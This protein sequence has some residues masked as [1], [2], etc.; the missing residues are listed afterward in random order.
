[1]TELIAFFLGMSLVI[2][3]FLWISHESIR[4]YWA[5]AEQRVKWLEAALWADAAEEEH[6][7]SD[8]DLGL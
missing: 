4:R 8:E 1:M 7:A 5:S 2:N 6:F 3:V